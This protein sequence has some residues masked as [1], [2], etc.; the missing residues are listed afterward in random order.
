MEGDS[1]K[2]IG[3]P[4]PIAPHSTSS[5]GNGDKVAAEASTAANPEHQQAEQPINAGNTQLLLEGLSKNAQKRLLK[6]AK[7]DETKKDR[8]REAKERKRAK[9]AEE[10]EQQQQAVVDAGGAASGSDSSLKKSVGIEAGS[11]EGFRDK[12]GEK[13]REQKPYGAGLVIDLGFDEVMSERVR[14]L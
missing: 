12:N 3:E 7:H 9:K 8:R 10:K 1:R 2:E 14:V 11:R 13:E 4:M 6:R 5:A